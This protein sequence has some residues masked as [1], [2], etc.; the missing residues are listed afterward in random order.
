[1]GNFG[2][3]NDGIA[4]NS[5]AIAGVGIGAGANSGDA[6]DGVGN[7]SIC[8]GNSNAGNGGTRQGAALD[9]ALMDRIAASRDRL[10]MRQS[11]TTLLYRLCGAGGAAAEGAASGSGAS[12]EPAGKARGRI[13]K[14]LAYISDNYMDKDMSLEKLAEHF[15]YSNRFV[16]RLIK[17]E[18]GRSYKDYLIE[19]RIQKA[20]ELLLEDG[21]T[22]T[23][24]CERVGFAY[25]PH[26]IQTFRRITGFTP[27]KYA[28]SAPARLVAGQ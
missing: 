9:Y 19:L 28:E 1:V 6:D 26:F 7:G 12:G 16:S 23:E 25:L 18:T 2:G 14:F 13:E 5:D 27:G 15:G 3:S 11:F 22:V 20:R 10:E 4:G 24:V 17:D 21:I 8:A